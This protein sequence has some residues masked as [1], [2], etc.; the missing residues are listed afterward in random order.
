MTFETPDDV[1]E[2]FGVKGMHWG[3]RKKRPKPTAAQR[4]AKTA[5]RQKVAGRVLLGIAAAAYAVS[6]LD[7][8]GNTRVS[9]IPPHSDPFASSFRNNRDYS[10]ARSNYD[11]ATSG[12]SGRP[13]SP[14]S[15]ADLINQ[16]RDTQISSL[17]RTHREGHLD[18]EQLRI[19]EEKLNRRYDRRVAEAGGK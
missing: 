1:L 18:A 14:R 15:A 16:E 2:H 10:R 13:R 9:D 7:A 6:I 12:G 11:R 3:V 19:F 17:R 8:V 4:R 5:Q